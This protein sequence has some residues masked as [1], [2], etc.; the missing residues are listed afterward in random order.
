MVYMS[1][2]TRYDAQFDISS[3]LKNHYLTIVYIMLPNSS[4]QWNGALDF[5]VAAGLS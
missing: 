3:Q 5:K 1:K 2:L 4:P